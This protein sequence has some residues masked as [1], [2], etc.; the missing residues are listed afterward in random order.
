MPKKE[1]KKRKSKVPW[2]FGTVASSVSVVGVILA[3][4]FQFGQL[5]SR[6]QYIHYKIEEL[7]DKILNET[8]EPFLEELVK[9][10]LAIPV[11]TLDLKKIENDI[12]DLNKKIEETDRKTLA[13]RQAINPTKPDEV[14]TIARLTDAISS[15]EKETKALREQ[16]KREL[17][18]FKASVLRELDA[19][20]KATN[21]ILVVLVPLVLN[22]I[23]NLWRD[24]QK[25]TPKPKI[26]KNEEPA[27]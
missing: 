12:A 2:F 4:A 8:L 23:Y 13:L 19:S 5:S 20:S 22:L 6:Q 24:R 21:L 3:F 10:K 18:D 16:N 25:R 17:E 9:K 27:T 14:L 7:E 11:Q 15:I 1:T 26:E